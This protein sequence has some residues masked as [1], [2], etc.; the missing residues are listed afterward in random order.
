MSLNHAHRWILFLQHVLPGHQTFPFCGF[1]LG[2]FSLHVLV[3]RCLRVNIQLLGGTRQSRSVASSR[4][5]E[6]CLLNQD[7]PVHLLWAVWLPLL[8]GNNLP[9]PTLFPSLGGQTRTVRRSS[10][11]WALCLLWLIYTLNGL[12]AVPSESRKICSFYAALEDGDQPSASYK[13][14]IG[15]TFADIDDRVLSPSSGM[16]SWKVSK[17]LQ[18]LGVSSRKFCRFEEVDLNKAKALNHHVME[19]AGLCSFDNLNKT[20]VT[21]SSLEA[22]DMEAALCSV[23]EA[24]LWMDWWTYAMKSLSLK[25]TDDACL[26]CCLSLAGAGCQL[27]VAKTASTL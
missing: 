26:V 23:V 4:G 17:V 1:F 12:P 2:L 21:W 19:L 18:Y 7:G 15:V 25:F 10:A 3:L 16:R 5:G 14:P 8:E 20:D 24:T 27:L 22:E 6:G 13:L 9:A 11:C